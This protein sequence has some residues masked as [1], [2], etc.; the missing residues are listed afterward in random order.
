MPLHATHPEVWW[1]TCF[2]SLALA[3]VIGSWLHLF[4]FFFSPC[5]VH[6]KSTEFCTV[7]YRVNCIYWM[8]SLLG[9]NQMPFSLI[10]KRARLWIRYFWLADKYCGSYP[11]QRVVKMELSSHLLW[12]N[13]SH[14]CN[15]LQDWDLSSFIISMYMGVSY[16]LLFKWETAVVQVCFLLMFLK[17]AQNLNRQFALIIRYNFELLISK[18]WLC[19][20]MFT[21]PLKESE[22]ILRVISQLSQYFVTARF[23]F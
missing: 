7:S 10:V 19:R 22:F 18:L 5:A 23:L 6:R 15:C 11:L 17:I 21:N 16:I 20:N 12:V 9:N 3:V 1:L 13:H 14:V 4:F 2:T 8:C